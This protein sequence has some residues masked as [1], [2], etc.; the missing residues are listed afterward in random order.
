MA[1]GTGKTFTAIGCIKEL[2]T[3]HDKL[4]VI[5]AAPYTNL[6]DQWQ[7]E[8]S[9]WYIDSS[10]LNKRWTQTIFDE[11]YTLNNNKDE[12]LKTHPNIL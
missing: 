9:K 1:T 11:V 3:K 5:I 8:I 6:V 2:E 4:L 10:I 12:N 7:G